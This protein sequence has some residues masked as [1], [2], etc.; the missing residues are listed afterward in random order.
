MNICMCIYIDIYVYK[1][2]W[3]CFF[4][5][6]FIHLHMHSMNFHFCLFI[7]LN[8]RFTCFLSLSQSPFLSSHFPLYLFKI[9]YFLLLLSCRRMESNKHK[10]TIYSQEIICPTTHAEFTYP[11]VCEAGRGAKDGESK[12]G[13]SGS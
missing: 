12:W 3:I 4:L 2:I 7:L 9:F 6:P 8:F 10:F 11:R 13:R 1:H 5:C